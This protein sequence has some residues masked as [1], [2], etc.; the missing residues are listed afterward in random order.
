MEHKGHYIVGEDL[1]VQA[2][3]DNAEKFDEKT[4]LTLRYLQIFTACCDSFAHVFAIERVLVLKVVRKIETWGAGFP[5]ESRTAPMRTNEWIF[6][7]RRVMISKDDLS[8]QAF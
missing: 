4:E 7:P 6:Y 3:Y 5:P 2:I 8:F 1:V